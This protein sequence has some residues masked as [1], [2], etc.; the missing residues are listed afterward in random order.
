MVIDS[1]MPSSL[2]SYPAKATMPYSP[3]QNLILAALP[4][5][6]FDRL[7]PH[8]E[9]VW[10]PLGETI[11]ESG[12]HPDYVFFPVNAIVSLLSDHSGEGV[13][14]IG[15]VGN[16][17]VLGVSQLLVGEVTPSQAVVL[18]AGYGYRLSGQILQTEYN[19][20]GPV[21]RLFLRYAQALTSQI[22]HTVACHR[23]HSIEQQLCRFLLLSLDRMPG[24][25]LSMTQDLIANMLGVQKEHVSEAA[26]KLQHAGFITYRRGHIDV[27][28]PSGLK[29]AACECYSLLKTDV[30]RLFAD[31]SNGAGSHASPDSSRR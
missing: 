3:T 23:Q 4:A 15:A 30:D 27:V 20:A 19:R 16:E 18:S 6:E 31:I 25:E 26:G 21:L 10:M 14:E 8:L 1:T 2:R 24:K 12:Q 7:S 5:A 9:L 11:Y 29:S 17:G 13:A 28:D 22:T